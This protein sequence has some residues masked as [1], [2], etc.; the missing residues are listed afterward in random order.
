MN[1][2]LDWYRR[3]SSREQRL[4]LWGAAATTVLLILAVLLP[5]Q[6][7]VSAGEERLR[8]KQQDLAW[9]QVAAPQLAAMGEAGRG[10]SDESLVVLA[11]RVARQTGIAGSLTGSQPS[12][13]GGLRVRVEK[14][15]FD[16]LTAWL[17]QLALQYGVRIENASIDGLPAPGTV[18]ATLVLRGG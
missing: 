16:A 6:R 1:R 5:L 7:A 17:G 18:N 11:D 2:L 10:A 3:L 13:D 4:V 9:L 8:S 12:G 14:V 15:S